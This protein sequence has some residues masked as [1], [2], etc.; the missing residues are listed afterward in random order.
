MST[1]ASLCPSV[2][3]RERGATAEARSITLLRSASYE[4]HGRI[5]IKNRT[6]YAGTS[7][8]P[9]GRGPKYHRIW[10]LLLLCSEWEEV[11][12][13]QMKHRRINFC[14]FILSSE[15]KCSFR[16]MEA[17]GASILLGMTAV[18]CCKKLSEVPKAWR[19]LRRLLA[20]RSRRK[21]PQEK[22]DAGS[23]NIKQSQHWDG[24]QSD[25]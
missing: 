15:G 4:G 3:L 20:P 16:F 1:K 17:F 14:F 12:H 22:F 7:Y 19:R 6:L 5:K 25:D 24:W 13:V 9:K 11:G 10:T 8:F 21:F 23:C 18:L 2:A